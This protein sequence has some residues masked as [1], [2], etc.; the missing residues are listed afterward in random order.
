MDLKFLITVASVLPS[1]KWGSPTEALCRKVFLCDDGVRSSAHTLGYT[2]GTRLAVLL[3]LEEVVLKMQILEV[4]SEADAWG[5][6]RTGRCKD[7]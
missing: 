3:R 5:H 2:Q 4:V 6:G 7:G 1:V